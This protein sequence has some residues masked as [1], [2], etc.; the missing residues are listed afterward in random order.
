MVRVDGGGQ[1]ALQLCCPFP[2]WLLPC[3]S[4]NIFQLEQIYRGTRERMAVLQAAC[5]G[6]L[7]YKMH[8]NCGMKYPNV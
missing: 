1:A 6:E 3:R 4:G 2:W 5:K 7:P 8:G